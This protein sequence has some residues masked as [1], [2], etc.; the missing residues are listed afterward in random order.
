MKKLL[1]F[2]FASL[3]IIACS[4]ENPTNA[5]GNKDSSGGNNNFSAQ[6]SNYTETYRYF[7]FLDTTHLRFG[8]TQVP[9][10]CQFNPETKTFSWVDLGYSLLVDLD[11]VPELFDT[12]PKSCN[13]CSKYWGT[14]GFHLS[15]DTL[16]E[17]TGHS[18]PCEDPPHGDGEAIVYTGSSKSLFG[19]WNYKGRYIDG[20]F[21]ENSFGMELVI[22]PT[23]LLNKYYYDFN[24]TP[25]YGYVHIC[26]PLDILYPQDTLFSQCRHYYNNVSKYNGKYMY[27]NKSTNTFQD[28][29]DTVFFSEN[30]WVTTTN[31]DVTIFINNNLI[32]V[33]YDITLYKERTETRTTVLFK[34]NQCTLIFNRADNIDKERCE[35]L[36]IDGETSDIFDYSNNEEYQNCLK[37]FQLN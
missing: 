6:N 25:V 22:T 5:F 26:E 24:N 12:A 11:T 2:L 16:Y 8:S 35:E 30:F 33:S 20:I 1:S 18:D 10:S 17:C 3:V 31:K 36:T 15:N 32:Q 4:D 23:Y 19:T 29:L 28:V 13:G 34:D 9:K 7:S 21:S 37:S 14:F 27:H